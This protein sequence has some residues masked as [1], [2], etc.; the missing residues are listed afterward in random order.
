MVICAESLASRESV[1]CL[2]ALEDRVLIAETSQE[3]DDTPIRCPTD[4][5]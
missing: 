2:I 5:E 4:G 3:F 1:D